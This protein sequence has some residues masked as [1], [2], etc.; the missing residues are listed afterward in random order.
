MAEEQ[1]VATPQIASQGKIHEVPEAVVEGLFSPDVGDSPAPTPLPDGNGAAALRVEQASPDSVS[2]RWLELA[3]R[4]KSQRQRERRLKEAEQKLSLIDEVQALTSSD[5]IK[6]AKRLGLD[7]YAIAAGLLGDVGPQKSQDEAQREAY[8]AIKSELGEVKVQNET[9][10]RKY[11][12]AQHSANVSQL[13]SEI[14][15]TISRNPEKFELSLFEKMSGTNV[16]NTVFDVMVE[17]NSH[18]EN[19]T[20]DKAIELV[21]NFY[22][23]MY[24]AR[25]DGVL[26]SKWYSQS[27]QSQQRGQKTNLPPRKD[28]KGSTLTEKLRG[29]SPRQT[30]SPVTEEEVLQQAIASLKFDE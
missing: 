30:G 28:E 19:P 24:S 20:V 26:K 21:E 6:A 7:P 23:N 14:D 29:E 22:R 16:A 4:D 10:R 17:L 27:Q 18:G 13:F 8:E 12:D 15:G 1:T 9:F 25:I 5:P 11:E 3:E 2:Q